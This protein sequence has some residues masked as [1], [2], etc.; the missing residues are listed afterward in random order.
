MS[1]Y[2]YKREEDEESEDEAIDESSYKAQKDALIFGIEISKSMLEPPEPSDDKKA[3]S[4]C[5]AIAALKSAYKIMQQRI[6][7][8]PKDQM[9]IILF[10]TQ[11]SK[12]IEY[13]G[14]VT[15]VS[16]P[17][18]YVYQPLDVPSAEDVKKLRSLVEDGEDED[19]V[20]VPSTTEPVEIKDLIICANQIFT[21]KAPN[22]GSRRLFI[23]T[24]NDDPHPGDKSLANSAATRAN[25]L[26]E[27]GASIEIF[28]IVHDDA[29][30]DATKF[31]DSIVH[32]DTTYEAIDPTRLN[33]TKLGDLDSLIK[34]INSKQTPKRAYFSKMNFELGPGMVISVNG[35]NILQKQSPARSCYVWLDGEKAQ[36]ATSST[37]R[38]AED[39]LRSVG[40]DEMR[41]AYKFGGEHVYFSP[42]EL[43]D[44]KEWGDPVIRII[45]FKD[46]SLLDFWMSLKKGIFI[47]PN[48]AGYVGS[49]RVFSALWQKLLKSQKIG[50]AWHVSRK[51]G[52]PTLVAIIPSRG[53][54]DDSSGT[55]YLPAGLWL[56]PIPFADDVR[57]APET[58]LVRATSLMIDVMNNIV[59]NLQLPAARYDPFAYPNPALQW[60]YRILQLLALDEEYDPDKIKPEDKTRPKVK[61]IHKRVGGYMQDWAKAADE[62]L[63]KYEDQQAIKR[64]H[65][66]EDEDEPRPAKRPRKAADKPANGG[67]SSAVNDAALR[68][69][70]ESGELSKLKVPEL[71]AILTAR[72]LDVKGKKADLIERLEEWAES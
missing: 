46:R 33:S 9:G 60:H 36:F 38:M 49:T 28:P 35:Y 55:Q 18:C 2:N 47:Y 14:R 21:T 7:S 12:F 13:E 17:H 72:G 15:T 56:C 71:K 30:F 32:I 48:E 37:T 53:P 69:M 59:R 51:N 52:N 29:K 40:K 11:K 41:R 16:Y 45:G 64:D 24:D 20:L 6:I 61:Q 4:D 23:I 22:F 19:E 10:G 39:D 8:N 50:I 3:S 58:K 43:K 1:G 34:N 57:P 54:D 65:D 26:Y 67:D 42:E 70:V 66:A 62:E 27:L 44:I 25:D 31:Y 68:K 63:S 5:A